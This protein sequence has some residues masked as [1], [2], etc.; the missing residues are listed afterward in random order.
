MCSYHYY[1]SDTYLSIVQTMQTEYNQIDLLFIDVWYTVS[2]IPY[3][4][5]SVGKDYGTICSILNILLELGALV[6]T[7]AWCRRLPPAPSPRSSSTTSPST[8]VYTKNLD[9]IFMYKVFKNFF[10][11]IQ[12]HLSSIVNNK[13]F[14]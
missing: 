10:L 9:I 2:H 3:P 6:W 8:Q 13:V 1:E 14:I 12:L 5:F 4:I 11:S 7:G